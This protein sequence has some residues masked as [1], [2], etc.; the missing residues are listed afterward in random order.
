[1]RSIE[2]PE[3]GP[4]TL[5]PSRRRYR[6]DFPL[7]HARQTRLTFLSSRRPP[8]PRCLRPRDRGSSHGT[9]VLSRPTPLV[10]ILAGLRVPNPVAP[11]RQA[12]ASD[13][14]RRGPAV[15]ASGDSI[16]ERRPVRAARVESKLDLLP[17]YTGCFGDVSSTAIQSAAVGVTGV[18][19]GSAAV[20]VCVARSP[21]PER[22]AA[23]A[24]SLKLGLS[25]LAV[26]CILSWCCWVSATG[27][28]DTGTCGCKRVM[29]VAVVLQRAESVVVL[30]WT[31]RYH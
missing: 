12:G 27:L 30:F 24:L 14:D 29:W 11:K 8:P 7:P 22:W 9:F 4:A 5:H 17:Q 19:Q 23:K 16:R 25:C 3:S 28:W 20:T 13:P 26:S 1:M 15:E 10:G 21:R 6:L 18:G 2:P 31:S